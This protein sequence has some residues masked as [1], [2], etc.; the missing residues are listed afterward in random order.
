MSETNTT[1]YLHGKN[2]LI[3][4]AAGSIGTG[5]CKM[6]AGNANVVALDKDEYRLWKLRRIFGDALEYVLLDC[7]DA[8]ALK[9][10]A[11]EDRLDVVIHAAAYKHV[12]MSE[13][14]ASYV[15][16]NNVAATSATAWLARHHR[17]HYVLISTDKAHNPVGVMA[18]SKLQSERALRMFRELEE[19]PYTVVRF[20]NVIGSSGSV[21]EVFRSSLHKPLPVSSEEATRYFIELHE[22]CELTHWA[23]A[24]DA[25]THG[26][27]YMLDMGEPVRIMDIASRLSDNIEIVGLAPGEK[28]HEELPSNLEKTAHARVLRVPCDD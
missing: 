14:N 15:F 23:A 11:W 16:R 12:A 24:L 17:A 26:N 20:G 2:V 10:R 8:D 3:T 28:L 7:C 19:S 18:K 4:G 1:N 9:G 6:L 22:A 5:L 21:H 25:G 27:T 13:E